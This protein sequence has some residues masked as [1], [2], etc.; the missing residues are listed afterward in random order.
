MEDTILQEGF[1]GLYGVY[2]KNQSFESKCCLDLKIAS[3]IKKYFNTI[4][5]STELKQIDDSRKSNENKIYSILQDRTVG[6]K[7]YFVRSA[8]IKGVFSKSG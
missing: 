5:N 1:L 8:D 4:H 2:L 6:Q 7:L 3:I